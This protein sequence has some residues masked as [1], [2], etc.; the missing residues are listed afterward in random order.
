MAGFRVM[1]GMWVMVYRNDKGVLVASDGKSELPL[2][3]KCEEPFSTLHPERGCGTVGCTE[4][5]PDKWPYW[6]MVNGEPVLFDP[7]KMKAN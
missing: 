4:R 1:A 7:M 6:S 2:C 5:D 3:E